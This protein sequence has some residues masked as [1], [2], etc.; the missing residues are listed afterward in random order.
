MSISATSLCDPSSA[1]CDFSRCKISLFSPSKTFF[2][3]SADVRLKIRRVKSRISNRNWRKSWSWRQERSTRD[4]SLSSIRGEWKFHSEKSQDP[5]S[6]WNDVC[7]SS[8][9]WGSYSSSHRS[10]IR[11]FIDRELAW[12]QLN[13]IDKILSCSLVPLVSL[14]W[15]W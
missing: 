13:A 9:K 7:D 4:V 11:W 5:D 1:L 15:W 14:C 8:A 6:S 2:V 3:I 10:C 12:F